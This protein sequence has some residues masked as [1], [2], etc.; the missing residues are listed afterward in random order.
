MQ[1]APGTHTRR[2]H[3][4]PGERGLSGLP[5]HIPPESQQV[6]LN[7]L[8]DRTRRMRKH[9]LIVMSALLCMYAQAGPADESARAPMKSLDEQVPGDKY[10]GLSIAAARN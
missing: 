1:L 8:N 6:E 4:A 10:D 9:F 2:A 5:T 3:C 7:S